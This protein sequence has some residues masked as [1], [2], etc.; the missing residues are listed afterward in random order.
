MAQE[1]W[2]LFSSLII[3]LGVTVLAAM[4]VY[5]HTS[6]RRKLQALL[7]AAFVVTITALMYLIIAPI[8]AER[9][10]IPRTSEVRHAR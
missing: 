7:T 3:P 5:R 4:F 1:D 9:L 10:L 8:F 6:K 2:R